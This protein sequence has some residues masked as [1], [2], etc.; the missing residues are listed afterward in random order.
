MTKQGG[1]AAQFRGADLCYEAGG[2]ARNRR[3]HSS[4]TSVPKNILEGATVMQSMRMTLRT[5]QQ[6]GSEVIWRDNWV[7][8]QHGKWEG[9]AG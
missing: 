2:T 7:R 6:R 4:Q 9:T 1:G 5:G 8:R 3:R